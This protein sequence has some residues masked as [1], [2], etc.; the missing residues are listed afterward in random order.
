M[1]AGTPTFWRV[2]ES[3]NGHGVAGPDLRE[4]VPSRVSRRFKE[5]EHP[6]GLLN[7]QRQD[8]PLSLLHKGFPY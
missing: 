6:W 4:S 1:V 8:Q 2:T 5:V 7:E 3:S